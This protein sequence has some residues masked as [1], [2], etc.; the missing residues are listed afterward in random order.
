MTEANHMNEETIP[1]VDEI[2]AELRRF[3]T[4]RAWYLP[5]VIEALDR[6]RDAIAWK[7]ENPPPTIGLP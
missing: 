1:T 6:L 4:N 3:I 5:D 2:A 7:W